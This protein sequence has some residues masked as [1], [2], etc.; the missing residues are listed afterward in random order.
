M[1]DIVVECVNCGPLYHGSIVRLKS[2]A[3]IIRSH[4]C[5]TLFYWIFKDLICIWCVPLSLAFGYPRRTRSL[6]LFC[7]I[8]MSSLNLLSTWWLASYYR[9]SLASLKES[10]LSFFTLPYE[11]KDTKGWEERKGINSIIRRHL[12]NSL[13]ILQ[14][15]SAPASS[16][17]PTPDG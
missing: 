11:N 16:F 10:F 6:L 1:M 15:H 2:N 4:W 8:S 3:A 5:L 12:K 17:V 14:R 7:D 13:A 9:A